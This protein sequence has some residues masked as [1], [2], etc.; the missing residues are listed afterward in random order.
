MKALAVGIINGS[1]DK[2][3]PAVLRRRLQFAGFRVVAC[4]NNV[5]H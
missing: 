3:L 1:L 2:N 5:S 4:P